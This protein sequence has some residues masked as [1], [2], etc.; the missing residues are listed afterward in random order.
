M[1]FKDL[2]GNIHNKDIVKYKYEKRCV[3]VSAGQGILGELLQEI[4]P[5][6]TIYEEMPCVG[7]RL[8]I[9]FYIHLFK[10]AFEFDGDQHEEYNPFFH[11]S[12]QGYLAHKKRDI[13]KEKWC[14]I[15]QIKLIRV[16]EEDLLTDRVKE[17]INGI[18]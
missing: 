4:Y 13:E 9:D 10:L 11:G 5:N 16:K 15:N 3:N 6:I 1:K 17:L 14:E 2:N 18:T 8:R 12:R 7:T